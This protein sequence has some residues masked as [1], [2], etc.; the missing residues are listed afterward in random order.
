MLKFEETSSIPVTI[1]KCLLGH[2]IFPFHGTAAFD[3]SWRTWNA[4]TRGSWIS[5]WMCFH[6]RHGSYSVSR[7]ATLSC[8][9]FQK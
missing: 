7:S 6:K 1:A 4:P 9:L 5:F 2:Y 3:F 8:F